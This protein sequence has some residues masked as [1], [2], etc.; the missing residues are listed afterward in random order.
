MR[1]YLNYFKLRIMTNLQ[2]RAAALAGVGTQV[3]FGLTFVML[4]LALYESNSGVNPPM[5]LQ[6]LITYLWLQQTF[7]AL[8]YPYIRDQELLG[9]IRNGNLAYE[10]IRPQNFYF[11]YYI[12]MLS[13]RLVMCFLRFSPILILAFSLPA[14][15][16]MSLPYSLENFILFIFGLLMSAILL[17]SLT[18]LMH[19]ITMF[20][21]EG[22]GI[23][24]IYNMSS[25]VFTGMIIPI[26][27]LPKFMIAI[28][29]FLPFRF[30]SDFPFRVYSGDI[31]INEGREL[32]LGSIIW[33]VVSMIIGYLISKLA[34]KKAVIQGG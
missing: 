19:I 2:Y 23:M 32:L 8:M 10:L 12:K 17:T 5:N 15:Y 25:Q 6:S 26:P 20:T 29:K 22:D 27:F 21:L 13:E 16:R 30:I 28:G 18:L 34:L 9:M 4:Y 24:S 33:L 1:A 3:F 31:S 14:P 7:F 11:K